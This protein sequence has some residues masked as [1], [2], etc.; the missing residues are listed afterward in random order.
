MKAQATLALAV[1]STLTLGGCGHGDM[2]NNG[3]SSMH[4]AVTDGEAENDR[5]S[6]A[7]D[8]AESMPAMLS[9]LDRHESGMSQVM[10]R[11]DGA[12]RGMGHCSGANFDDLSHSV[13][14]LHSAMSD[15]DQRIRSAATLDVARAEC[16]T[17]VGS[18]A[19]MMQNMMGDLA[20][21]SCMMTYP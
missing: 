18:M 13:T 4:Q 19:G 15:H 7:C 11:V 17:H 1:F 12:L 20:G 8:A 14:Q 6:S 5:H 16:S 2:M 9:E 21:M 10:D 3:L